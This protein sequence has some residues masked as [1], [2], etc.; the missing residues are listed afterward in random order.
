MVEHPAVE[1]QLSQAIGIEKV[2]EFREACTLN[3]TGSR[4]GNPEPS[5]EP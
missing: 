4:D 1:K 3:P 5:T 2:G